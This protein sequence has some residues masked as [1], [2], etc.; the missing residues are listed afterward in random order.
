MIGVDIRNMSAGMFGGPMRDSM[1]TNPSFIDNLQVPFGAAIGFWL[2]TRPFAESDDALR[3]LYAYANGGFSV[4]Q[5]YYRIDD[6]M[7]QNAHGLNLYQLDF[8]A[9]YAGTVAEVVEIIGTVGAGLDGLGLV[10]PVTTS[11]VATCSGTHGAPNPMNCAGTLDF[12]SYQAWYFRPDL[13]LRVRLVEDLLMLEGQ[14][15]GRIVLNNFGD[16]SNTDFGAAG[17]GGLDF[18]LGLA[19]IVYPSPDDSVGFSW[20]ARFGYSGNYITYT[21]PQPP[22]PV[23]PS[24]LCHS[25]CRDGGTI[26]AWHISAGVGI[27][28]R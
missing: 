17:G 23:F 20:R 1:G 25:F 5:S 15:A 22:V 28:I 4:G 26:E 21:A 24:D 14:F 6:P 16:L 2:E 19:G 10:D 9:G 7:F 8:G 12:P 27:A 18:S 3:G 13:Q 11:A